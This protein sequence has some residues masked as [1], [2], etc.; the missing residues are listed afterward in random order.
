MRV[1]IVLAAGSSRR[2]GTAN[3]LFAR[4]S[5]KTLLAHAIAAARRAPVQRLVVATGAQPGRVTSMVRR[6]DRKAVVVRVPEHREG[7]GASLRVASRRLRPIDREALIFLA[8]MP[9]LPTDM[10]SRLVRN[11]RRPDEI[12]RP[13][14]R[15]RPGHPV[16]LRGRALA[17]LAVS[18]EDEGPGRGGGYR[19]ALLQADRRCIA[20]VDRPAALSRTPP[21]LC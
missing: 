14:W 20:D 5:G 17:S 10:A 2:F 18:R 11:G 1:A 9:W 19:V 16:L 12:V 6:L 21:R 15:G 7:L 3:K 13:A 8:D 4:Y